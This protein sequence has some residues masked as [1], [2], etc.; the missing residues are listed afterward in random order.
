[1]KAIYYTGRISPRI[2]GGVIA[3]GIFDGMHV[4]HSALLDKAVG[5]ARRLKIKSAAITFWPHP[6]KTPVICSLHK[7]L[8]L[9]RRRGL[10]YCLILPFTKMFSRI[11]PRKFINDM[12]V[13][14]LSP[15]YL[16]VGSNFTFG[17]DAQGDVRLLKEF[18]R[19][20]NFSVEEVKLKELGGKAVS[21]TAIRR[22]IIE[23]RLRRAARLL[24]RD[25]TIEGDVVS[26]KKLGRRLGY[27]TINVDYGNEVLPPDGIYAA[28]ILIGTGLYK[29]VCY[30]GRRPTIEKGMRR[31]VEVHIF[32]F[33]QDVYGRYVEIMPLKFLRKDA[34][35]KTIHD[36][37]RQISRDIKASRKYLS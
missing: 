2:K 36:L 33:A 34:K 1:M 9:M 10:D 19:N 16:F 26:S 6:A 3:I 14:K 23:G 32:D 11:P 21:S 27:P 31:S 18:S 4:G 22:L 35:F 5:R 13:K 30:I 12:I 20:F 37:T 15:R 8:E 29:G 28:R 24:G 7:R 17:K 25:F